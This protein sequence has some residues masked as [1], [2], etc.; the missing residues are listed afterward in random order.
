[1]FEITS[2]NYDPGIRMG[3]ALPDALRFDESRRILLSIDDE[4]ILSH[5]S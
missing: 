3:L 2:K 4:G 1:M 5:L